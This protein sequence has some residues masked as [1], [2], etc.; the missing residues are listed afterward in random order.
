[1]AMEA[2]NLKINVFLRR[3]M[4]KM[5]LWVLKN[6]ENEKFVVRFTEV[7]ICLTWIGSK[8]FSSFDYNET[9]NIQIWIYIIFSEQHFSKVVRLWNSIN[10]FQV[11]SQEI[12]L[13]KLKY[14]HLCNLRSLWNYRREI[15]NHKRNTY[16]KSSRILEIWKF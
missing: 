5:Q 6:I 2:V 14:V 8:L 12:L 4:N 9:K 1:M 13:L 11:F 7:G 16:S 15:W 10:V 3:K